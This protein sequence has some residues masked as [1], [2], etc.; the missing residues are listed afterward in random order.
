M[1]SILQLEDP[2]DE[3]GRLIASY[4]FACPNAQVIEALV[5]LQ[6]IV[7]LGAGAGYWA[8]LLRDRGA[9]VFAFDNGSWRGRYHLWSE[10]V[11]GNEET[12]RDYED[13]TLLVVMPGRPGFGR[14]VDAW[15]G[16]RMVVVTQGG[17]P[18]EDR[19]MSDE[20]DAIRD[21]GWTH[22]LTFTLPDVPKVHMYATFW[23]RQ[24]T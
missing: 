2:F 4:A 19:A 9:D 15:C 6:P 10:V 16:Q 23:E 21:G 14:I 20:T 18:L 24:G 11:Q 12:L 17:F 1:E 8:R 3:R 5:A 13:R 7:E 22:S